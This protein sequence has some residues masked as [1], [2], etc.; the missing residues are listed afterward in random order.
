LLDRGELDAAEKYFLH[1][2]ELNPSAWMACYKM[3]RLELRRGNL[4]E[5]LKWAKKAEE[6]ET[7]VP[8]IYDLL[9]QIHIQQKDYASAVKDVDAY[10][11]LEQNPQKAS[12]AR[13]LRDKLADLT[14]K[15]QPPN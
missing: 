9:G 1:A 13:Q 6:I 11:Q 10:I 2:V 3:G 7:Q 12:E 5:A 15:P 14:Q 4:S 8:V